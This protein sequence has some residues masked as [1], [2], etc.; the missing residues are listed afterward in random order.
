VG[1]NVLVDDDPAA[2][3]AAVARARP[4]PDDRPRLYG[5]GHASERVA[6]TLL[7]TLPGS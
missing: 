4:L 6:R 3:A 5:D 2:L 7:C 1:A